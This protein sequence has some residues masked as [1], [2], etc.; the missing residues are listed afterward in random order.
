MLVPLLLPLTLLVGDA[1]AKWIQVSGQIGNSAESFGADAFDVST[2]A[3]QVLSLLSNGE[4][5]RTRPASAT[6]AR[7]AVPRVLGLG[8]GPGL[9]LRT[10]TDLQS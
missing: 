4:F 9:G 8:L 6:H 1:H 3:S 7:R 2:V 10:G 5:R